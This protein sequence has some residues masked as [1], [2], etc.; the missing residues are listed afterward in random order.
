MIFDFIFINRNSAAL[1]HNN[2]IDVFG[3]SLDTMLGIV[4]DM[5]SNLDAFAGASDTE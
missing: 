4:D 3:G 2:L 5:E 1:G